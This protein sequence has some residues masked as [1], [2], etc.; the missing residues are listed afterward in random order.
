MTTATVRDLRTNFPKLKRIL[1]DEEEVVITDHGTP[2]AVLKRVEPSAKRP[3]PIDYFA[4]L[5]HRMPKPI[6][7]RQRAALDD[8]REER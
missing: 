8:D 3:K 1:E 4:R 6:T 5:K 2:V 7:K